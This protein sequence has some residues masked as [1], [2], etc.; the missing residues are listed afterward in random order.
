MLRM[1][2]CRCSRRHPQVLIGLVVASLLVI[3]GFQAPSGIKAISKTS[4][5]ERLQTADLS[6]S[7]S[8]RDKDCTT[9]DDHGCKAHN[10]APGLRPVGF[11][12]T[13]LRIVADAKPAVTPVAIAPQTFRDFANVVPRAPPHIIS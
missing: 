10:G 8:L 12:S 2:K 9:G 13:I 3:I 6:H 5:L 1:E 4:R 7:P 11:P